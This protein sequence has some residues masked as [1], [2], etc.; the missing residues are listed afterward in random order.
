MMTFRIFLP[1]VSLLLNEP[2]KFA[3]LPRDQTDF[4]AR[5]VLSAQDPFIGGFIKSK[6]IDSKCPGAYAN[7]LENDLQCVLPWILSKTTMV[8][9]PINSP[10]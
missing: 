9:A 8:R 2:S 5:L 10:K 4:Q 6:T 7:S 3:P 1:L